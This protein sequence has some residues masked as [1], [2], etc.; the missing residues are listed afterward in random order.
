MLEVENFFVFMDCL[1]VFSYLAEQHTAQKLDRNCLRHFVVLS[2]YPKRLTIVHNSHAR[3]T[4][5]VFA[6]GGRNN[7]KGGVRLI[8]VRE[9]RRFSFRFFV[10]RKS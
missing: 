3:S 5:T 10:V 7:V 1:V 2:D 6:V 4:A 9:V 8:T